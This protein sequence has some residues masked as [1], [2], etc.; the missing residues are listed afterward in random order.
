MIAPLLLCPIPRA[1]APPGRSAQQVR[2]VRRDHG[3]RAEPD[4][5]RHVV[6]AH[7]P[8]RELGARTA[9]LRGACDAVVVHAAATLTLGSSSVTYD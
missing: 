4:G 7:R 6:A 3:C 9:V 2:C 1:P 8:A 5:Y